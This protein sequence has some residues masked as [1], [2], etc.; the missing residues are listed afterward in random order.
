MIAYET[1][2][3]QDLR[4]A[5]QE[6]SMHF[7]EASA[8]HR[9]LQR[10]FHARRSTDQEIKARRL[11]HNLPTSPNWTLVVEDSKQDSPTSRS[12]EAVV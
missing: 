9:T 11:T 10:W 2:L 12:R 7:E 5:L 6:G 8:V 4:W 3:N 1:Q